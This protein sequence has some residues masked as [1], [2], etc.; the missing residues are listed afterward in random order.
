MREYLRRNDVKERQNAA[1]RA[2]KPW[3][4]NV[5]RQK[6][7]E[8]KRR[9]RRMAALNAG[10][11]IRDQKQILENIQD[12]L[13]IA[14]AYQAWRWFINNRASQSWLSAYWESAGKPWLNPAIPKSLR[15]HIRYRTDQE[16][17]QKRADRYKRKKYERRALIASQPNAMGITEER[18]LRRLADR[19]VYCEAELTE[20]TRTLDHV[21]PL[22]RGGLH[23]VLNVVAC[24]RSCN[25]A[26]QDKMIASMWSQKSKVL[27][28]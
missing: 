21:R 1:R 11:E 2:N 24:C 15:D 17:R 13:A 18:F 7:I 23:T 4:Q 28:L 3:R 9:A 26:K 14:N 22:S 25:S 6:R 16:F 10:R 27:P 20:Q 5:E 8:Y 12:R 19:C